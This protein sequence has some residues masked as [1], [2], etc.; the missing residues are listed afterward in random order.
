MLTKLWRF[1]TYNT[2]VR[3]VII[4]SLYNLIKPI[5]N[6]FA[7]KIHFRYH[8]ECI[9]ILESDSANIK[10]YYCAACRAIDP[11]LKTKYRK[12]KENKSKKDRKGMFHFATI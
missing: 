9:N 10:Y 2:C 12:N 6:I 1:F 8:G 5:G 7:V 4:H 11:S 3:L